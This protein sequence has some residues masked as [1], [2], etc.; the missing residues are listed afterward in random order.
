[1]SE[2]K[3]DM[4]KEECDICSEYINR[5]SR[6]KV[7]CI[8][9]SCQ[10]SC[11]RECFNRYLMDSGLTPK[12]MWCSKDMSLEFVD[13]NTT[14]KFY[15]YYMDYRAGLVLERCKVQ[16]PQ[17]QEEVEG[18]LRQRKFQEEL[19]LFNF[20]EINMNIFKF[21]NDLHLTARDCLIKNRGLS[22]KYILTSYNF[23][24][25]IWGTN[26]LCAICDDIFVE[27]SCL[28]CNIK[29]CV[30]C[31][32]IYFACNYGHCICSNKLD[33]EYI[34][35]RSSKTYFNEF[36]V[37]KKR[38]QEK[39]DKRKILCSNMVELIKNKLEI[40]SKLIEFGLKL[41]KLSG[42][43]NDNKPKEVKIF[44]QKCPDTNCR[45]FLSTSWKCGL[46]DMF[47]C[48]DCHKKK[49]ERHDDDHV[50]DESE[51]ATVAMLKKD[52]KPCPQC[53]MPIDRYT[54]CSQVWTPCC[55]I[56]FD[57]N[58]GK[59]DKGRIHSPE[60][61]DFLR[62]TEGFVPR[63]RGDNICGGNISVYELNRAIIAVSTR[64]RQICLN[65]HQLTEHVNTF[66]IP[67]LP[68]T[69]DAFLRDDLGIR[70]LLNEIDEDKWKTELKKR[71]KKTE[72]ENHILNILRMFTAVMNDLM[73]N[74]E[75]DKHTENFIDNAVKVANY[76]NENIAKIQKRYKSVDK[77]FY[78]NFSIDA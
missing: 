55:K 21:R 28:E 18:V 74:L 77:S 42:R 4:D 44:N 52:T 72:K 13:D 9:D 51:K 49:E 76:T 1:M 39:V 2:N 48:K 29:V 73:R 68:N 35:E 33:I 5:S 70:Y 54:G 75:E 36:F 7:T 26:S 65:F 37:I 30:K 57:W 63:E 40:N 41:L 19:Q 15:K 45:G 47:F 59:I 46:C 8:F 6:K 78:I 14:Q 60:Y 23:N 16:L 67:R 56:A 64:N 17:L 38:K 31:L 43:I 11:C 58:T 61:Y 24:H 66:M 69:P 62:R 22:K 50:C 10:K 34:Y 20:Q 27:T 3:K 71:I 53:G 32:P 12:C 25:E